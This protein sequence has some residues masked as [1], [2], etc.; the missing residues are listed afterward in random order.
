MSPESVPSYF[1]R[2]VRRLRESGFVDPP[3]IPNQTTLSQFP[4]ITGEFTKDPRTGELRFVPNG[5]SLV[6]QG[7]H[8]VVFKNPDGGYLV[9]ARST[10]DGNA[11]YMATYDKGGEPLEN[12]RES[13]EQL[14]ELLFKK[15][16]NR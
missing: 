14:K 8:V 4:S 16:A 13:A 15:P 6:R 11:E 2:Y 5:L 3:Q 1:R 9:R 7:M 12:S 10:R